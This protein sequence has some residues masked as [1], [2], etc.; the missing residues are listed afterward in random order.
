MAK[1]DV[2]KKNEINVRRKFAKN[3]ENIGQD[4]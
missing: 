3:N 2:S 4:R 1:A